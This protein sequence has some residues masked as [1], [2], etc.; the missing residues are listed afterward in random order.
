MEDALY[1]SSCAW[2]IP[3]RGR[4]P[5][6]SEAFADPDGDA[7]A[8]T[9]SS[10]APH[11]ATVLATVARAMETAVGRQSDDLRDRHRS[12][13]PER[14]AGIRGDGGPRSEPTAGVGGGLQPLALRVDGPAVA[15]E[16]GAAFRGALSAAR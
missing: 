16:V 15:V 9:V 5:G 7:L 13:R 10:S 6:R 4:F 3:S 8:Y 2:A 1:G 12:R 14:G 11:V